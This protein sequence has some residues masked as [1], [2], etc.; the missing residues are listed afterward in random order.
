MFGV[1]SFASSIGGWLID[2]VTVNMI[3]ILLGGVAL[4]GTGVTVIQLLLRVRSAAQQQWVGSQ[5]P[6]A[7]D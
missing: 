4:V 6:A 5:A 1:G 7:T 3:Y 2:H